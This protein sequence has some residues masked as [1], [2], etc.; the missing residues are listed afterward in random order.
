MP[1]HFQPTMRCDRAARLAAV[2]AGLYVVM[3]AAWIALS[4]HGVALLAAD[5]GDF[6]QLQ[7][8]K[9]WLYVAVTGLLLYAL[10]RV[11]AGRALA[12]EKRFRRVLEIVPD[13]VYAASLD[14]R[15]RTFV[16]PAASA[17]LGLDAEERGDGA[18]WL[19]RLHAEDRDHVLRSIHRQLEQ[20]GRF[21]VEYRMWHKDEASLRWF[22]DR[23]FVGFDELRNRHF[24]VGLMEDV[25]ELRHTQ[26]EADYLI[27]HD[28]L[29]RLINSTGFHL[30]LESH[31]KVARRNGTQV[32]CLC[33]KIDG[34]NRLNAVHGREAGDHV[35][36]RVA[37]SVQGALREGD[38]SS[39]GRHGV[40][41][42]SGDHFLVALPETSPADAQSVAERLATAIRGLRFRLQEEIRIDVKIGLAAFPDHAK[43]AGSLLSQV[44]LALDRA[45][46]GR[47]HDVYV[48]Q[49]EDSR[50]ETQVDHTLQ[51]L[52]GALDAGRLEVWLQPI[53][54]LA[55]NCVQRYEALARIRGPD[56]E[57]IHPVDFID[58]AERFGL[59]DRLDQ[60]VF[61]AVLE[62]QAEL[63][64]S[65]H[66]VEICVNLSR[67]HLASGDF[68][69]WF[70][71]RVH[72]GK[73]S[74][75]GL[76]FEITETAAVSDLVGTRSF[77]EAA[78]EHGARFALDDFG[79]GFTSF[80]QLRVLPVD[81]VKIDGAFIR[82]LPTSRVD[83]EIVRSITS[84]AKALGRS[85]VA[86]FVES[87]EILA[88]VRGLGVDD[89]QGYLIGAPR[90]WTASELARAAGRP[91][92]DEPV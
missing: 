47:S 73:D 50:S 6:Q 59:I 13:V 36:I 48:L 74:L 83:R 60:A 38:V 54:H 56:G 32:S 20:T 37:H 90:P 21:A 27:N 64:R 16:N 49:P 10:I 19:K 28:P 85:V 46:A 51:R 69:R 82:N 65:R 22:K 42:R 55:T 70:E 8:G 14:A 35:L 7:T 67:I 86:E 26:T 3:G 41:A 71:R 15:R 2:I 29:T 84:I 12:Y 34:F 92:A 25:T 31:L 68:L 9:G 24:V 52:R 91:S 61:E 63:R 72:D 5:V 40:L 30:L 89:A 23:G 76:V 11:H 43:E 66:E 33:L 18:V 53:L 79:T 81:S 78:R 88:I 57:L 1:T 45:D 62:L 80:A 17:T 44:E 87:E 4:D 75:C 39:R 77:M 58:T